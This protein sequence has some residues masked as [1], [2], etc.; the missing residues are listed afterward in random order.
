MLFIFLQNDHNIRIVA[1]PDRK[2]SRLKVSK[3]SVDFDG[4]YQCI[5]V[6][7]AGSVMHSFMIELT[8]GTII[9]LK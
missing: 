7:V 9:T 3:A 1:I 8:Q 6:N 2:S 4:E 5:A